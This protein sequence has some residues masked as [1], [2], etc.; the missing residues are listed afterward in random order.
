M[1]KGLIHIYCGDGKGKT[2]AAIGL[3]VRFSGG[4]GRVALF[5]FMKGDSSSELAALGKMDGV[6]VIEGV[7]SLKFVWD[8]TASEKAAAKELYTKKFREIVR[9]CERFDLLVLDEVMSAISCG[10]VDENEVCAFLESKPSG[11]EV[12]LTGRDPSD[13]LVELADYVSEVRKIKHPF[14][15]GV[16]ARRLVEF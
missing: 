3:C 13:R 1:K 9:I 5:Q 6:T 7:K 10:F 11:L 12:V 15:K 4:G 2:T 16:A 14:D 8:M